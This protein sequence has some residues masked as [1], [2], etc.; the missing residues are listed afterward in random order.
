MIGDVSIKTVDDSDFSEGAIRQKQEI[1]EEGYMGGKVNGRVFVCGFLSWV[2]S[3]R[4]DF[5]C[6]IGSTWYLN[7]IWMCFHQFWEQ[8][9][10][11]GRFG[12]MF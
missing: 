3:H 4:L 1:E 2:W 9:T 5:F 12:V 8:Q 11:I 7:I 6:F 10:E